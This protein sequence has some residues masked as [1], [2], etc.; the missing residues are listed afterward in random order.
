[1][2]VRKPGLCARAGIADRVN[3]E[4][5]SMTG[6]PMT[7]HYARPALPYGGWSL[8]LARLSAMMLVVSGLAHRFGYMET[9]GFFWVL[10][11]VFLLAFAAFCLSLV[12]L[13]RLWDRGARGGRSCPP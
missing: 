9:I 8:F 5:E 3:A 11:S 10:G 4:D 2:P 13:N 12:A 6:L 7:G 1:M